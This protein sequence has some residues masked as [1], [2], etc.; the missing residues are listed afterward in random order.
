ML[1]TQ[2]D[3]KGFGFEMDAP[4][5]QHAEGVAGAV[6][7]REDYVA[8]IQSL[9]ARQHHAFDLSP[10][11]DQIGNLA[12]EAHFTTKRDDLL[13]HP[14]YDASETKRADVRL[15]DIENLRRCAGT[16]ELPHHLATME[17]RVFDLAVELAVGKQARAALAKL[18]I[19]FGCQRVPPPKGPGIAR[20]ASHITAAFQH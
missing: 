11:D 15:A 5:L 13:A 1:D 17:F 9:P 3:G 8:A 12:F 18:N 4:L 2:A 19:G 16:H 10:F 6:P 14:R 20:S 7:Q